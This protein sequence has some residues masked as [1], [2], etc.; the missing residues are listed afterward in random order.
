MERAELKRL[1]EADPKSQDYA[2]ALSAETP[3]HEAHVPSFFLQVSEV[4][5]E[6]YAVFVRATG[7]RPPFHWGAPSIARGRDEYLAELEARKDE[8]LSSSRPV[9]DAAPFDE[10][11]WWSANWPGKPASIPPGDDLRPVVFVD[12]DDARAYAR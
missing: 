7:R 12:W 11:A 3:Q 4:T 6:Q 5:N 10:Q 2:G 8:A 1:L 9:P